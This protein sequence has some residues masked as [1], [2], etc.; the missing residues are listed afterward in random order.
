MNLN[1]ILTSTVNQYVPGMKGANIAN[2]TE[3]VDYIKNADGKIEG[4]VL[5]DSLS[6]K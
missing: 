2:Y 3:F 6:K 1:A 5:Y 4:A